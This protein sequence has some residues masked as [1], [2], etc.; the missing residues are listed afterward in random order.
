LKIESCSQGN[1]NK[2]AFEWGTV[3]RIL[4]SYYKWAWIFPFVMSPHI[5]CFRWSVCTW[6]SGRYSAKHEAEN[7]LSLHGPGIGLNLQNIIIFWN[8][9]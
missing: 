5:P 9:V 3:I 6:K 2:F 4:S 1:F 8:N 7:V